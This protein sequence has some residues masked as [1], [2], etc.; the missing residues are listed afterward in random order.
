MSAPHV[1]IAHADLTSLACDAWLVPGGLGPGSVWRQ[2]LPPKSAWRSLE[3]RSNDGGA[4]HDD[5][6]E[7]RAVV[8]ADVGVD[9]P[10]PILT[11]ISGTNRSS[12]EW[13]AEGARAFLRAA[14]RVL[15][16][17]G[18]KPQRH[19]SRYL[20]AL[21][22]AG[23]KGGGGAAW[24]GEI[25]SLL[26]PLLRDEAKALERAGEVGIDVVLALIEGPAWAAAQRTRAA[27]SHAFDALPPPLKAAADA[28]AVRA[29][30]GGLTLFLG[31]GVAKPAG[32]PDWKRLL[33]LLAKERISPAELPAFA[34]LSE[35]DRAA[36][37]EQRLAPGETMGAATA[38]VIVEHSRK[39]A[40]GHAL[41]ASLPVD[42][43][44]TTNY[45]DLFERASVVVGRPCARI[46]GGQ[47]GPGQRFIL[48]MHGCVSRPSS[49]VLTREDYLRFQENRSA[50]AGIVQALLLTRH[51]LFVG[52]SFT[53]DNFHRI[54]HAVRSAVRGDDGTTRAFGTNLVLGSAGLV[55]DL[56]RDDLDWLALGDH[57][58]PEDAGD[59]AAQARLVEVFL[60]RLSAQAATVTGHLGDD[61]WAGALSPEELALRRRLEGLVAA[62][63]AAERDTPAWSEVQILLGRL[64]IKA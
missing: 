22:L 2:G 10:I 23:T 46:P 21:P 52:F 48:K 41:L 47:V 58:S 15:R 24:S 20:L 12:P 31:A 57:V 62:T 5:T 64:G 32:L 26:L 14:V 34:R 3:D 16:E 49:I 63:T 29:R 43:V 53:D 36:L 61:R 40:V 42:E 19:R 59:V 60:D 1:F 7:R 13:Y 39:I 44:V 11:D 45:D 35:L 55:K 17:S 54:A 51:M 9:E 37:I 33:N 38:R 50:L 6:G 27:D 30:Q 18:R 8:L 56:W 25:T 4:G 28:L